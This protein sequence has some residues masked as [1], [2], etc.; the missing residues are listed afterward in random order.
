M[1]KSLIK[2]LK[3]KG[4]AMKRNIDHSKTNYSRENE[5]NLVLFNAMIY[6][7][8]LY[9]KIKNLEFPSVICTTKKGNSGQEKRNRRWYQREYR[10][11]WLGDLDLS[12]DIKKLYD[13][14]RWKKDIIITHKNGDKILELNGLD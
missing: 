13:A 2:L 3:S 8:E 14:I 5:E 12:K 4:F 9:Y 6:E 7:K 10:N 1:T 11:I